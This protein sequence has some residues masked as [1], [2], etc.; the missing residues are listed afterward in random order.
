MSNTSNEWMKTAYVRHVGWYQYAG[1]VHQFELP[2]DEPPP[3]EFEIHI[4]DVVSLDLVHLYTFTFPPSYVFPNT[5]FG[6]RQSV[7]KV[8]EH[9]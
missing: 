5:T 6:L 9:V 2:V 1:Q 8:V 4:D 3:K 7:Y